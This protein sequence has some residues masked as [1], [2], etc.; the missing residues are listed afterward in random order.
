MSA[1][2]RPDSVSPTNPVTGT[3]VRDTLAPRGLS[4]TPAEEED[5]TGFLVGGWEEWN[6]VLAMD[7]YVPPVDE[8]RFRRTDVHRPSAEDNPHNA[9]AWKARI[10]DAEARGGLL[11]GKTVALKVSWRTTHGRF[12]AA[13]FGVPPS[14][15]M[16]TGV[17]SPART[18]ALRTT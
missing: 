10:E 11:K 15:M 3:S 5:Y 9:W 6:K 4:L 12:G 14:A 1:A 8:K 13:P 17:V 7:D 16:Q 2:V 18:A